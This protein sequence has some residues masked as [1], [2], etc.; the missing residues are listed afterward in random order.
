[1]REETIVTLFTCHFC[2]DEGYFEIAVLIVFERDVRKEGMLDGLSS[3]SSSQMSING[4][5]DRLALEIDRELER[6]K[7]DSET[8][9]ES[10][11]D[12]G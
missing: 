10:E 12:M 1:M 7:G 9:S 5:R 11:S 2:R 3:C 8:D 6:K 4:F